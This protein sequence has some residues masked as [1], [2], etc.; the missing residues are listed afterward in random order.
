MSDRTDF[1][2]SHTGDRVLPA[3]PLFTRLLA[4]AHRP[5]QR[6]VIRDVNTGV[7]KTSAEL[8]SD[9]VSLRRSL[10]AALS[11]DTLNDLQYGR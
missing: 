2:P 4:L 5:K 10:R 9:V 8:L 1:V 7:E 6:V 3:D 11:Q